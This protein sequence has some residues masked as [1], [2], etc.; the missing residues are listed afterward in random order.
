LNETL[1]RDCD[2]ILSVNFVT[3]LIL[4]KIG[5]YEEAKRYIDINRK[6]I[7]VLLDEDNNGGKQSQLSVIMEKMPA[8]VQ[9]RTICD[10]FETGES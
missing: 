8:G 3:F 2:Y 9:S 5:K 6:L 4:W 10:S 1:N 7:E